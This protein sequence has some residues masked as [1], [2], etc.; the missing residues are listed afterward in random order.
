L[1][2]ISFDETKKVRI[3]RFLHTHSH[4]DEI[5]EPEH[6]PSNLGEARAVLGDLLKL[7][8]QEDRAH[9][10]AMKAL[11]DPPNDAEEAQ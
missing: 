9:Y 5:G 2:R 3:L 1:Q 11:V 8:E 4:G 6:D 7:I 10:Q